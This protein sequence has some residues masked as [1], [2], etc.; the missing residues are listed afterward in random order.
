MVV[1]CSSILPPPSSKLSDFKTSSNLSAF[2]T[3]KLFSNRHPFVVGQLGLHGANVV[4]SVILPNPL[5]IR[6]RQF[7]AL[8]PQKTQEFEGLDLGKLCLS[9]LGSQ[10]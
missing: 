10:L 2:K 6:P 4:F 9:A 7:E 8:V 5:W 1:C 3:S